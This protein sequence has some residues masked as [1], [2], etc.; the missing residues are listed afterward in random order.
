MT[1]APFL[2]MSAARKRR[3]KEDSM[4]NKDLDK[5]R[6]QPPQADQQGGGR[7]NNEEVGEPIQLNEDM[8]KGEQQG[9][10]GMGQ[11]QGGKQDQQPGGTQHPGQSNR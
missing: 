11:Q 2:S 7:K 10:P 9:K 5:P 1:I 3:P 4:G 6:Q 8:P